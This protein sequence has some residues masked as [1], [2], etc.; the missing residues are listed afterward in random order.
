MRTPRHRRHFYLF[1][2]GC[3]PVPVACLSASSVMPCIF[4]HLLENDVM[5]TVHCT[6]HVGADRHVGTAVSTLMQMHEFHIAHQKRIR[7]LVPGLA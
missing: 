4:C 3:R 1:I 2:V 5:H 6:V 7:A